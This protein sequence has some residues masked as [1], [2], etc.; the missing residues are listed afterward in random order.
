M[1]ASRKMMQIIQWAFLVSIVLYAVIT[2]MLPASVA[3]NVLVFRI[4]MLLSVGT[5]AM[6]FALRRKL[7]K[8]A[9]QILSVQPEDA[10]ALARWRTGYLI[11]YA[12]SEAV[13]LYGLVLHFMGFTFAQ[14]APFF[15]AGF[16]LML[17]YAPRRP[18]PTR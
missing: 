16:V 17:F 4:L 8:P 15:I 13:A 2:K 9:E 3:P 11:T 1:D 6:I 12:F 18:A 7:V 5:V 10:G 14:V